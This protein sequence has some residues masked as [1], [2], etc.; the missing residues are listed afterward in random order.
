VDGDV[1]ECVLLRR[2][3]PLHGA[4]RGGTR[5]RAGRS[6]KWTPGR[7]APAKD[8]GAASTQDVEIGAVT[9]TSNMRNVLNL[10]LNPKP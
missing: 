1:R 6:A 7:Q 4:H 8:Y 10:T 3:T 5:L 2:S 9:P